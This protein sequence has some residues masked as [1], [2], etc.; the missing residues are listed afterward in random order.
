MLNSNNRDLPR[1]ELE[2]SSTPLINVQNTSEIEETYYGKFRSIVKQRYFG[3]KLEEVPFMEFIDQNQVED[4]LFRDRLT[5]DQDIKDKLTDFINL[6]TQ[7]KSKFI[8]CPSIYCYLKMII[9][10]F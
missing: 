8:L 1:E 5:I 7:V 10:D 4:Y 2:K 3:I 6:M 9:S